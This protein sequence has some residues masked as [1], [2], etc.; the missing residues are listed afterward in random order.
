MK[1]LLSIVAI[2]AFVGALTVPVYAGSQTDQVLIQLADEEPKK[3]EKEKTKEK[4]SESCA[5]KTEAKSCCGEKEKKSCGD[6]D[7]K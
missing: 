4:K 2:I 6:K 3:A 1:K 5:T 7:K